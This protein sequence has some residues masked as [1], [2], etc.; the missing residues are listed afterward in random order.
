MKTIIC[1]LLIIS[2]LSSRVLR[3]DENS[4]RNE[5][6]NDSLED[7]RDETEKNHKEETDF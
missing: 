5:N 6:D 7:N 3:E 4:N 1:S 2:I